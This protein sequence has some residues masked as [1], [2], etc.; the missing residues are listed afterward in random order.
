M[1]YILTS[2]VALFLV[3]SCTRQPQNV[4]LNGFAQGSTYHIVI[5]QDTTEGI[6]FSIDSLINRIDKS[7]SI[8]NSSSLL[9]KVNANQTDSLDE[10]LVCC[11]HRAQEISRL[12][13]GMF[14]IT[15]M[16][17]VRAFGFGAEGAT[18]SPNVD[19]LLQFVGYE[20]ISIEGDRL[21]KSDPR[22]QL[23]LNAIAQGYTVDKLAALF[24]HY[25]IENYLIELG[26]EIYAKGE[27]PSG[28]S[29]IVGID[30]PQE[31]NYIPGNDLIIK[32]KMK[33]RGLAT[34]GNYRKFYTDSEGRKIVHTINPKS[35]EPVV[36]SLLSATVIAC[37][38][39]MADALGTYFMVVGL[40]AAKRF[41][42]DN[43]EIDALL[44]YD[45]DGEFKTFRTPNLAVVE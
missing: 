26:G 42:A 45:Q 20:K 28:K 44:V 40:E 2:L 33:N 13:D 19:S 18:Q 9:S 39:T 25:G 1:K 6:M 38:A 30:S 8:Y 43:P 14:D 27:K 23:D 15:V 29:W 12:T 16:P 5:A 34:S 35:G 11:L 41:L 22:V 10:H 24:D 21:V 32:L 4:I 3:S 17:L 36:S 7:L 31:G 37:A